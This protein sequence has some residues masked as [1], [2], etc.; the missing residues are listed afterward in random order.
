MAIE[1]VQEGVAVTGKGP[2]NDGRLG[3]SGANARR[4]SAKKRSVFGHRALTAKWRGFGIVIGLVADLIIMN[5]KAV[6]V[7][8]HCLSEIGK[9]GWGRA[10]SGQRDIPA[11]GLERVEGDPR[12]SDARAN[13]RSRC[14]RLD[15]AFRIPPVRP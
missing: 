13:R 12:L 15:E 1:L 8:R 11:L 14:R 3:V 5:A 7:R 9:A 10:T 2:G 6:Q 4:G